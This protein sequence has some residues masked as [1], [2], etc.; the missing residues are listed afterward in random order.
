[1]NHCID[2]TLLKADC[3][4]D[5][6]RR[7]CAE[8]NT[9]QFASVC[10]LPWWVALAASEYHTVCTV[11]GF[12]L[13]AHTTAI[14]VAEA[15]HL[16]RMGAREIDV[17]ASV[18]ALKSGHW[19]RVRADVVAVVD[20]VHAL[21]GLVKVI[22]ETSLL[23]HSEKIIMCEVVT[24]AGA[25][26]IKTSTGF[27]GGGATVDDVAILR[28]H[29]G[30]N[31]LVKASGGIRDRATAEAMIEAGAARIGTSNGVALVGEEGRD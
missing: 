5:Q 26:F 17:V 15:E 12:P 20:A 13:G 4:E 9:Y 28:A 19:D 2:H 6:V 24:A 21:G 27:S 18:T 29:V 30:S 14:K 3:T 25:D 11:V 22:I 10:V 7:L 23:T 1:M 31:V 16:I 8:A